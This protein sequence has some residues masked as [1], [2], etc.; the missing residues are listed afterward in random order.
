MSHICLSLHCI[1]SLQGKLMKKTQ[2]LYFA[3]SNYFAAGSS[4]IALKG[5]QDKGKRQE[6]SGC[7][8]TGCG[9]VSLD[10]IYH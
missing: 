2:K 5:A 4:E 7:R 1:L 8:S 10:P 3:D 6:V 9:R